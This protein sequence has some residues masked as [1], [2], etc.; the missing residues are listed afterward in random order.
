MRLSGRGAAIAAAALLLALSFAPLHC[1][2]EAPFREGEPAPDLRFRDLEGR[3]VALSSF[4]GRV[5]VVNFWATWCPP[6]LAELPSL[7]RLH[8]ALSRDGLAVL[9]VSVDERDPEVLSFVKER[10]LTLSV[11]RDR[12]G[13]EAAR[14]LGV[15]SYPTTFVIDGA[16]RLRARY[17]GVADWDLPEALDHFRG[18]LKESTSPTR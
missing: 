15:D 6:C 1:R 3:E 13:A 5:V 4:K 2:R 12:G 14:K 11:L 10:G 18:L 9:A 16:G 7:D 17:L 8:R